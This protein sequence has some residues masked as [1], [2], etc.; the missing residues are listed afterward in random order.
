MGIFDR[1]FGK[2][3]DANPASMND[4]HLKKVAPLGADT[5]NP[6]YKT[7]YKE[8]STLGG[9]TDGFFKQD[10]QD[11][12]ARNAVGASRLAQG[13]NLGLIPETR[14]AEHKLPGGPRGRSTRRVLR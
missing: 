9:A 10:S 6:V 4:T 5:A 3:V 1:I 7:E 11:T 2:K 13:L 8:D 14:F 12:R